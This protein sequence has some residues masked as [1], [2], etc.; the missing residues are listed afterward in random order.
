MANK[1]NTIHHQMVMRQSSRSE[2]KDGLLRHNQRQENRLLLELGQWDKAQRTVAKGLDKESH[3]FKQSATSSGYNPQRTSKRNS[4]A[5]VADNG[6]PRFIPDYQYRNRSTIAAQP[7]G[8]GETE[9]HDQ[10]AAETSENSTSEK[11][12]SDQEPSSPRPR[13]KPGKGSEGEG[14][15][16]SSK[17]GDHRRSSQSEKKSRHRGNDESRDRTEKEKSGSA[18]AGRD[19]GVVSDKKPPRPAATAAV[20]ATAVAA[21]ASTPPVK[22][23][24]STT[25]D[26]STPSKPSSTKPSKKAA[27]AAVDSSALLSAINASINT[28]PTTTPTPTPTTDST[29]GVAT[30]TPTQPD[31]TKQEAGSKTTSGTRSFSICEDVH[32]PGDVIVSSKGMRELGWDGRRRYTNVW[33]SLSAPK[34]TSQVRSVRSRLQREFTQPPPSTDGSFRGLATRSARAPSFS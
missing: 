12:S 9:R 29:D 4:L 32:D 3:Y 26:K 17:H 7:S 24:Q 27:A 28:I 18:H 8:V 23:T 25:S 6:Q 31:V 1:K 30:T 22:K 34:H 2:F 16:S 19:S 10:R 14:K 13:K 11:K 21:E 15:K 33:D 5:E 20:A